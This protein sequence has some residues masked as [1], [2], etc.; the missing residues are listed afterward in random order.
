MKLKILLIRTLMLLLCFPL[1]GAFAYFLHGSLEMFLDEVQT[2]KVR[3]V[4][5]LFILLLLAAQVGLFLG[6]RRLSK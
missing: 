3:M 2:E 1:L 4:S 5:G 6:M